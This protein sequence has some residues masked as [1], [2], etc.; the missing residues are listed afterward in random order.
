MLLLFSLFPV[1]LFSLANADED[2]VYKTEQE[3]NAKIDGS[4]CYGFFIGSNSTNTTAMIQQWRC[5]SNTMVPPD[6][7]ITTIFTNDHFATTESIVISGFPLNFLK[8]NSTAFQQA[9]K[10]LAQMVLLDEFASDKSQITRMAAAISGNDAETVADMLWT[11]FEENYQKFYIDRSFI[12]VITED[13]EIAYSWLS[14]SY[15]RTGFEKDKELISVID[16]QNNS[17]NYAIYLENH[18]AYT[19]SEYSLD[20]AHIMTVKDIGEYESVLVYYQSFEYMGSEDILWLILEN[21]KNNA[22]NEISS[23]CH[24]DG[25]EFTL[26]GSSVTGNGDWAACEAEIKE[27]I[28][29]DSCKFKRCGP[30]GEAIPEI[31][32]AMLAGDLYFVELFF[33][34]IVFRYSPDVLREQTDYLCALNYNQVQE[35]FEDYN[36]HSY[37]F[38]FK[39]LYAYRLLVDG[40]HFEESKNL[41]CTPSGSKQW[42]QWYVG[43]AFFSFMFGSL[44]KLT[45]G[46][47][48]AV[49]GAGFLF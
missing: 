3:Y 46:A 45:M 10:D 37:D 31:E 22:T 40:F 39:S 15:F 16:L 9:V 47:T 1:L 28:G 24:P 5:R 25:A 23:P 29:S 2:R 11:V 36:G 21:H 7:P 8:D 18:D 17:L 30:A 41:V 19:L 49:L 13:S 33:N 12:E 44:L 42:F 34:R 20:E 6:F 4:Y 27:L 48:M 38:C 26:N 35:A 43:R 14:L 32:S